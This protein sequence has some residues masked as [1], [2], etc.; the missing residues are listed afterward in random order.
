MFFFGICPK[1]PHQKSGDFWDF[2]P[3]KKEGGGGGF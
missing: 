1:F 2:L 3:K